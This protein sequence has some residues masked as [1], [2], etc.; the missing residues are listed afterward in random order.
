[1]LSL[2][3]LNLQNL[4]IRS[5]IYQLLNKIIFIAK[6]PAFQKA[7]RP[8]QNLKI[9]VGPSD[10]RGNLNEMV[11]IAQRNNIKIVFIAPLLYDNGTVYNPLNYRPPENFLTVNSLY[12]FSKRGNLRESFIDNCH[13]T[14][15]GNRIE[16]EEIAEVLIK[17]S[18]F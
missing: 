9:R 13:L 15:K 8:S 6:H 1:M 3:V 4:L 10:Y 11:L 2:W 5:K 12:G 7:D 17:E 18:V 14:A 16:A